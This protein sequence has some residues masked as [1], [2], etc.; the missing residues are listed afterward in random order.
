MA[1]PQ[2]LLVAVLALQLCVV[3]VC[4]Q[5]DGPVKPPRFPEK[6]WS[7]FD[8]LGPHDAYRMSGAYYCDYANS[9]FRMDSSHPKDDLHTTVFLKLGSEEKMY[10]LQVSNEDDTVTSC[11]RLEDQP[12]MFPARDLL[13]AAE[14]KGLAI[15]EK[16]KMKCDIW[17][18]PG[19]QYF[20]LAGT[21]TPV[22]SK[23]TQGT[24]R[25]SNVRKGSFP[26][27]IFDLPPECSEE[28]L[29]VTKMEPREVYDEEDDDS[30]AEYVTDENGER[31]RV[32]QV[33]GAGAKGSTGGT[34]LRMG[35]NEL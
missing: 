32:E 7:M 34:R 8:V 28:N 15:F 27:G 30:D 16:E 22:M 6:W 18:V 19:T 24:F 21:D 10:G 3:C 25:L 20:F 33:A 9:N 14:Y 2:L 29:A 17:E 12:E 11:Q 5:E 26:R 35:R 1:R 4:G 13:Q 31:L 23:N